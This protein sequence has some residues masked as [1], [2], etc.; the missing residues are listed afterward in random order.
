MGMNDIT[1]IM[2]PIPPIHWLK[3]RQKWSDLGNVSRLSIVELPVV[4]K[5]HMLSKK[6]LVNEGMAPLSR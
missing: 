3:L 4:L 1:K 5:P 2:I 6:A